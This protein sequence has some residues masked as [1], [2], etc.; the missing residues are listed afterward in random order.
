MISDEMSIRKHIS[1]NPGTE[2]FDGFTTATSHKSQNTSSETEQLSVAKDA[3]VFLI[4]GPN[5]KL[6]IAYYLLNGLNGVD[7]AAL[8][9]E[10]IKCVEE[11]NVRL[12]SL[13]SDGLNAN[14]VVAKLLGAKFAEKKPYFESSTYPKQKI[15]IIFDPPH[16]LKLVRKHFSNHKLYSDKGLVNWNFLRILVDRQSQANFNLCNK[17][18]QHHINW[19]ERPMNVKLAAETISSSVA[20]VLEQLQNDDYEEFQK[21]ESTVEFLRIFNDLFDIFNFSAKSNPN[22]KFKRAICDES[23]ETIFPFLE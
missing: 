11:C 23:I 2:K 6:P 9:L 21:T 19:Y 1:W 4:V 20:D 12:I 10:A 15:Y 22:N 3:L 14:I 17:L 13:T 7:R 8:T 18:T 5:F 16:M